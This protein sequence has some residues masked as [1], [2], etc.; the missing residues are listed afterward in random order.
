MPTTVEAA[1]MKDFFADVRDPFLHG[2]K[3]TDPA[4]EGWTKQYGGEDADTHQHKRCVV[5]LFD[6]KSAGDECVEC[7]HAAKWTE[8]VERGAREEWNSHSIFGQCF[9][10]CDHRD[11]GEEKYLHHFADPNTVRAK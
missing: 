9:I 4:A 5:N 2:T 1:A 6:Q 11:E 8:R 3:R 7:F 10:N